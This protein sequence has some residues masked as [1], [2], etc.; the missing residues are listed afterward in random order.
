M[1]MPKRPARH[2]RGVAVITALLLTTLA[3]TIVASLF[4]QQQ[5]QVRS[6]ENQRTQLQKQWILRGALDWAKLILRSDFNNVDYAGDP[7]AIPLADVR[8][9]EFVENGRQDAEASS[10]VLSGYIVDAQARFNVNTLIRGGTVSPKDVAAFTRLLTNLRVAQAASLADATASYL[11]AARQ[12]GALQPGAGSPAG[13]GSTAVIPGATTATTPATPNPPAAATGSASGASPAGPRMMPLTQFDD[14]L[15][16]TGFS[17]DIL[18]RLKDFVTVL[19]ENDTKIN[20]NTATAEVLSAVVPSLALS[21]ATTLVASRD[22]AY[23]KDTAD[24]TNRLPATVQTAVAAGLGPLDV[25]TEHFLV[26]GKV[27]L[28]NAVLEIQSLVERPSINGQVKIIW[29]RET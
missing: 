3:V 5:V 28:N 1:S 29:T 25:K 13:G 4:W 20:V 18:A 23:F 15:A 17:S 11:L 27:K 10:A 14:L 8:L 22:R 16:V 24:F 9:D 7:W 21:D 2:Q 12:P 19:P 26:N 6:I